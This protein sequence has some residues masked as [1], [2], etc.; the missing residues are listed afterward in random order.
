MKQTL[1]HQQKRWPHLTSMAK[2]MMQHQ[3]TAAPGM[4]LDGFNLSLT[5]NDGGRRDSEKSEATKTDPI[6][7]ENKEDAR[8]DSIAATSA[9]P[10]VPP[11]TGKADAD[12]IP[13]GSPAS[14][15]S[16]VSGGEKQEVELSHFDH[17]ATIQG[18]SNIFQKAAKARG[19]FEA[20]APTPLAGPTTST[21][22]CSAALLADAPPNA[23][24][25]F[26]AAPAIRVETET[27]AY[28]CNIVLYYVPP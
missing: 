6:Q 24:P 10:L 14:T 23:A 2:K 25:A 16:E 1:H 8:A 22:S 20:L 13:T 11:N 27:A 3:K 4:V 28:T 26:F 7:L 12:V 5:C 18:A 17:L 21:T 15:S 9:P 19:I